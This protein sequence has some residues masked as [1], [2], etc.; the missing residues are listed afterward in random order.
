MKHFLKRMEK[1][2]RPLS[3]GGHAAFINFPDRELRRSAYE[4]GDNR[5]ELQR[6]KQIWD[7]DNFFSWPQGVRLSTKETG[8]TGTG[9]ARNI[10][11]VRSVG[12]G[13]EVMDAMAPPPGADAVDMET[14][15]SQD[16]GSAMADAFEA[17]ES[18][19]DRFGVP[20]KNDFEGG[21]H[22]LADLGF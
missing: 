15:E 4:A 5:Q 7:K 14:E 21:I 16:E 10:M 8:A 12:V 2:L 6:V 18:E 22:A 1:D 13:V 19:W 3:I 11:A 9:R 17:E 20:L